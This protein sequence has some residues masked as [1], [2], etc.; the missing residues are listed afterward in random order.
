MDA[1]KSKSSIRNLT[2]VLDI[3][4][5]EIGFINYHAKAWQ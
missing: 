4:F 1:P 2:E 3:I 5:I